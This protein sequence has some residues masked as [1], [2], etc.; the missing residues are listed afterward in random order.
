MKRLKRSR[1][2]L[3]SRG[4][5]TFETA[6]YVYGPLALHID[7]FDGWRIS[8][9]LTGTKVYDLPTPDQ[10]LLR[11]LASEV[12]WS[13]IEWDGKLVLPPDW[14]ARVAVIMRIIRE[15]AQ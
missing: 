11:R 13:G 15:A 10:A 8:H 3:R 9:V 7:G 6:A 12:D 14:S 4:G 1:I 5:K 2:T